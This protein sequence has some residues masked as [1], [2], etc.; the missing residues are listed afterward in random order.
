MS[1]SQQCRLASETAEERE[2][3]Q[4]GESAFP[5]VYMQCTWCAGTVR[6]QYPNRLAICDWTSASLTHSSDC[7]QGR[8]QVCMSVGERGGGGGLC[9]CMSVNCVALWPEVVLCS[10]KFCLQYV[11]A[12]APCPACAVA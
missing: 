5:L 3:R 2:T 8:R 11:H 10:V 6:M 1:L 9:M 12:T 4:D 7:V